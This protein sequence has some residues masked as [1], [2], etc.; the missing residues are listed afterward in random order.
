MHEDVLDNLAGWR[1]LC[2]AVVPREL[3]ELE[4]VRRMPC[5][6]LAERLHDPRPTLLPA[7]FPSRPAHSL[8]RWPIMRDHI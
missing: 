3:E 8:R 7:S 5:A 4:Q 1:D 6:R 2:V